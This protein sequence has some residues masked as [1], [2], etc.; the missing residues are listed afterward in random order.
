MYQITVHLLV[1][2]A[3]QP[4]PIVP[5]VL[6]VLIAPTATQLVMTY[7]CALAQQDIMY[8][9]QIHI[10]APS[11]QPLLLI[12]IPA[13]QVVYALLAKQAIQEIYANCASLQDILNLQLDHL[14]HVLNVLIDV[15]T[16]IMRIPAQCVPL[17]I[18]ALIA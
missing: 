1:P 11:A 7:L 12:V 10:P 8:L 14:T 9:M 16:A 17:H 2:L 13:L 5:H 3:L 15:I 4:F 6:I 18:V